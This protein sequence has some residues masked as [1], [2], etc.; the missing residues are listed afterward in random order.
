MQGSP[1]AARPLSAPQQYDGLARNGP[2][3]AQSQRTHTGQDGYRRIRRHT[4]RGTRRMTPAAPAR[5]RG[6][7]SDV[8]LVSSAAATAAPTCAGVDDIGAGLIPAVILPVT[9]PGLTSRTRTP[10]PASASARPRANA[11]RPAFAAP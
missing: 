11:S 7:Q 2:V 4:G 5:L 8:A 3:T 6:T 9:K 10:V 1:I